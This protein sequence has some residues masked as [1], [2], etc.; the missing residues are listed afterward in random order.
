[1]TLLHTPYAPATMLVPRLI[2][3][4]DKN[5]R[6]RLVGDAIQDGGSRLILGFSYDPKAKI[7]KEGR[8]I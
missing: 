3:V 1:M 2:E 4:T 8:A 6:T 7:D 5:G